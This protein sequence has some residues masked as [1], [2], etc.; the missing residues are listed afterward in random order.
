MYYAVYDKQTGDYLESGL[1]RQDKQDVK[2]DIISL[3]Y[4]DISQDD[5]AIYSALPLE[6]I[7]DMAE[8]RLDESEVKF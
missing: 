2:E 8:L 7:L 1:N 5:R 4:Y 3:F 6:E